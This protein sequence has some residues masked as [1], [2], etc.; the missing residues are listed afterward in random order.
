MPRVYV[1]LSFDRVRFK[2]QR[3]GA[4]CHHRR[5]SEFS[6]LIPPELVQRFVERSN[7]I[8]LNEDEISRISRIYGL[9][10]EE[11]V[12]TLYPY[13]GR[14]V[15]IS[16]DGSGVVLDIPVL[17]SKPDTTCVFYDNGC[18][19]YPHRPRACRLFPFRISEREIAGDVVLS[20]D[21]N[22]GCPGIGKGDY[23][24]TRKIRE[25]AVEIFSK[26]MNAIT[27]ETKELIASG[28]IKPGM[29]VY[30]TMPGGPRTR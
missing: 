21:Y 25:L 1:S 4:C 26:R 6:E 16:D 30:R 29:V 13:D 5:P 24:D 20:I 23:A 11:F 7:L 22:P 3:C 14:A 17:K 9:R 28:S 10:P 19:I 15:R 12:D 8:H 18:R 27:R 2:C